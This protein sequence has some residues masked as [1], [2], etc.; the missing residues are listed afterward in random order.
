M[1]SH[2][3]GDGVFTK[4]RRRTELVSLKNAIGLAQEVAGLCFIWN[5]AQTGEKQLLGSYLVRVDKTNSNDYGCHERYIDRKSFWSR[6]DFRSAL[7][8]SSA[9]RVVT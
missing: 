7:A 9:Q 4:Q 3:Q 8:C 2:S 6:V 1:Q 5:I